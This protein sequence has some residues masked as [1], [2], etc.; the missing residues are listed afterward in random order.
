[1]ASTEET[2]KPPKSE[3]Y[4]EPLVVP[5]LREHKQTFILLHGRGSNATKF[6]TALLDCAIP[7]FGP[8]PAAFP[9][10]K[11][12]FPTASLRRAAI[13]RRSLVHQWFDNWSLHTPTVKEELQIQGLRETSQFIHGLLRRE[14]ALVG[15]ENVVLGGLSQGCAAGLIAMLLWDRDPLAAVFG[16]CGYLPF[17]KHL[18]GICRGPD[19]GAY[20][21]VEFDDPFAQEGQI[22]FLRARQIYS[23]M[24]E[25]TPARQGKKCPCGRGGRLSVQPVGCPKASFVYGVSEGAHVPWSWG[26][27]RKSTRRAGS[28]GFELP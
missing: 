27:G 8:L 4:P 25:L 24:F 16:M 5:S 15:A 13:Y 14:I 26:R 9:Y 3:V 28:R 18:E 2:W 21:G 20:D 22:F 11:F 19:E 6:G 12:V 1:M 17:R 10:A 23:F 7:E